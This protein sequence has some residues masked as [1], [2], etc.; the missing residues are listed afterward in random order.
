[1]TAIFGRRSLCVN[2][3]LGDKHE[4]KA[5]LDFNFT[6]YTIAT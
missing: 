3:S 5:Y 1:M 6:V 2:N 4:K